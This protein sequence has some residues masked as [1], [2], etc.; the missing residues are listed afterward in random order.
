MGNALEDIPYCLRPYESLARFFVRREALP[1]YQLGLTRA[2]AHA[3]AHL[4][5]GKQGEASPRP[6]SAR[7][8]CGRRARSRRSRQRLPGRDAVSAPLPLA[9]DLPAEER[10]DAAPPLSMRAACASSG[11]MGSNGWR[12]LRRLRRPAPRFIRLPPPSRCANRARR[13]PTGFWVEPPSAGP[14]LPIRSRTRDHRAT[15]RA[16]STAAPAPQRHHLAAITTRYVFIRSIAIRHLVIAGE[17]CR[18]I[19]P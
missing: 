9:N 5:L 17:G 1:H 11:R 19:L 2:R 12:P 14:R 8:R 3:A 13:L 10:G 6:D 7:R 16:C 4:L 15:G 18:L